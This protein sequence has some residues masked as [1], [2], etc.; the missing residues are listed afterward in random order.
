MTA[1]LTP[2]NWP[3]VAPLLDALLDAHPDGRAALLDE[4]S[5]G[6]R[7]RRE[8]LERLL[9]ECERGDPLLDRPAS[10][11][12]SEMFRQE[13]ARFP[14]A[15]ADRYR[16]TRELGHGG[17][18]TVFLARDLRHDRD[19]AVKVMRP[20]LVLG[21]ER[22]LREIRIAAR[23]RHPHIVPLF[24]S[25][26][27]NGVLY[28]VMPYEEGE[29]LRDRLRR[30]GMMPVPEVVDILRDVC[31]A[32]SHAHTQGIIHRDIK[33]DNV[34]LSGR[35]AMVTDFGVARA[36]TE[37]AAG[38]ATT[39]GGV[40]IGTP[41]YMAPEQAAAD[42][43]VDHRADIYAVG[44]MA[45]E[46]LSGRPPFIGDTPQIVLA[47]ITETPMSV[48]DLRPDVPASLAA[49]VM[50]CLEKRPINRWQQA[51]ELREA[52]DAAMRPGADVGRPI[53]D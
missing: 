33:P 29:S 15:L 24:D 51:S 18:A 4:L 10:E 2:E 34:L 25:G 7:H 48:S 5:G 27:A 40:A 14:D 11:R 22:F 37:A 26:D 38:A 20:E 16:L 3:K 12:F 45:Y 44:V 52:F 46:L 35:A 17:M 41:A 53:P 42:P 6:D 31:D 36:I 28:Y 21:R 39:T 8:D 47:H 1:P 43:S 19:V 9:A 13:Q 49:V 23:L 32:L 50:K 30:E